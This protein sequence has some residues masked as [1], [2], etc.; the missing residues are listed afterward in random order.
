MPAA[1]V[2]IIDPWISRCLIC[3]FSLFLR[4][5]QNRPAV[6]LRRVVQN[7]EELGAELQAARFTLKLQVIGL[8]TTSD[9][10]VNLPCCF[11]SK[12]YFKRHA[13]LLRP[14]RATIAASRACSTVSCHDR[15]KNRSSQ[16]QHKNC[17]KDTLV[18]QALSGGIKCIETH[19]G[20]RQRGCH[21][22]Q[23]ERPHRHAGRRRDWYQQNS[24]TKTLTL[25][26]LNRSH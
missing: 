17:I 8:S 24:R 11:H 7:I 9:A 3:S 26:M 12:L 4:S 23:R 18:N 21:L 15:S 25:F 2:I 14:C 19:K 1:N 16:H 20:C 5:D 6:Q 10:I 22:R 13:H